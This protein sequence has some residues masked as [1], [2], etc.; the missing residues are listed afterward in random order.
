MD[1]KEESVASAKSA[2]SFRGE[3]MTEEEED[4]EGKRHPPS[5]LPSPA[6]P[7]EGETVSALV[8]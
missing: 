5:P 3:M 2:D 8:A 7:G 1:G 6:R 4:E